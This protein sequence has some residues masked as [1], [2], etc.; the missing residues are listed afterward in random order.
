MTIEMLRQDAS[1]FKADQSQEDLESML[2]RL[3]SQAAEQAT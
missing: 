2:R 3:M 1:P